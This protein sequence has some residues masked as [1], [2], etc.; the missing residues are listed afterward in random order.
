MSPVFKKEDKTV[1]ER[2]KSCQDK[3]GFAGV[4]LMDLSK[5]FDRGSEFSSYEIELRKT[6]SHFELLT[7]SRK[8]KSYTSSY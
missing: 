8:T 7:P 6:T 1:V 3:Q 4:L 5:A 2:R